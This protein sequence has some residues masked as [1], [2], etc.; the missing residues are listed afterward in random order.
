MGNGEVGGH[1]LANSAKIATES[2]LWLDLVWLLYGHCN[3]N[4]NV[5]RRTLTDEMGEGYLTIKQQ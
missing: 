2:R 3:C 5:R 1:A 4:C